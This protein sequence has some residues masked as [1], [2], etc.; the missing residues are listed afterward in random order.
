MTDIRLPDLPPTRK[1]IIMSRILK[2][3]PSKSAQMMF[4]ASAMGA[5]ALTAG[6]DL[7]PQFVPFLSGAGYSILADIIGRVAKND[8]RDSDDEIR[9]QVKLAIQE[10]N[11]KQLLTSDEFQRALG[12]L[13]DWQMLLK[14]DIKQNERIIRRLIDQ[15]SRYQGFAEELQ[16]GILAELQLLATRAQASEII[17]LLNNIDAAPKYGTSEQKTSGDHSHAIGPGSTVNITK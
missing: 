3:I 2:A 7:P 13:E 17:D 1:Q 9:R 10:S 14:Y 15:S 11:F 4:Y 5:I 16:A 8:D 6:A 12:K